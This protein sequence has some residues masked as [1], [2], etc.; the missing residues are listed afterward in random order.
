MKFLKNILK[1]TFSNFLGFWNQLL[2][3]FILPA[4]LS[5]QDFG[6]FRQYSLYISFSYFLNLGINDAIY[7]KYGGKNAEKL[8]QQELSKSF[9]FC[10]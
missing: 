8:N 1:V 4:V 7:V 9:S 3:G 10:Y 2:I 5:V 6:Y